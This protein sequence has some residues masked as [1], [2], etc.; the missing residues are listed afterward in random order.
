LGRTK[1]LAEGFG[2]SWFHIF[3]FGRLDRVRTGSRKMSKR[4][5]IEI[6]SETLMEIAKNSYQGWLPHKENEK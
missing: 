5:G 2:S 4:S 1:F 3:N 6:T